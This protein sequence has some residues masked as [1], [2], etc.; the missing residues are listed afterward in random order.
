VTRLLTVHDV[1]DGT[2][3]PAPA[4]LSRY[5]TATARKGALA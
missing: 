3:R 1:A 4:R 5:V 2:K